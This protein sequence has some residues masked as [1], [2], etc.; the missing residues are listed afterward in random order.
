MTN[1]LPVRPIRVPSWRLCGFQSTKDRQDTRHTC[2]RGRAQPDEYVVT[3]VGEG[4]GAVL[5]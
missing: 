2:Q 3:T 5:T 1:L 4:E